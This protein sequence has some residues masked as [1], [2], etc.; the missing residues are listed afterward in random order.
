[1]RFI[2]IKTRLFLP[3][4]DDLY[5]LLDDY[6]SKLKNKDILVISSKILSI[7]QGRCVK[8]N[9]KTDKIKL[10]KKEANR[11]LPDKPHSLTILDNTLTPYAGI[12]RSNGNGHYILWP[13]NINQS[14][15]QIWQYLKE[16]Y[17]L[18]N[19]GIIITDSFLLPLRQGL[20]GISIGFHGFYPLKS[21]KGK[22]DIFGRKIIR[23]NSD[24]VDAL[25][26]LA[27]VYMGEGNEQTPL[28]MIRGAEFIKFT[29]KN[30]TKDLLMPEK[31]DLY[32]PLLKSFS[33]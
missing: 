13:E 24:L 28:L 26:A 3:P 29:S 20:I 23:T 15:K 12:D 2:P 6:S 19:L 32:A 31:D 7:H 27:V 14:A 11:Y 5:Q 22:K 4:K 16:K 21:Y 10:I 33:S 25:S 17:Q 1:M 9:P 18:K 8:I 30:T